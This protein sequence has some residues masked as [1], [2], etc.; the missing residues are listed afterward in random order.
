MHDPNLH[1]TEHDAVLA[2]TKLPYIRILAGSLFL[3]LVIPALLVGMRLFN[4]PGLDVLWSKYVDPNTTVAIPLAEAIIQ[5]IATGTVV[6]SL[7]LLRAIFKKC[8]HWTAHEAIR[9]GPGFGMLVSFLNL[10]LY[11]VLY[12]LKDDSGYVARTILLILITGAFNGMWLA[13]HAWR[14][15]HPEEHFFPRFS[16]RTLMIAVFIWGAIMLVFQPR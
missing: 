9:F 13:W 11:F 1:F 6:V 8:E 12:I 15:W 16:L 4:N 14:A 5:T 2:R 7:I 3:G 10:P